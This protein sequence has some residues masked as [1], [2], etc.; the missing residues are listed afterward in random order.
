MKDNYWVQF[1]DYADGNLKDEITKLQDAEDLRLQ[2]I[3]DASKED[4]KLPTETN[5]P[6]A[7]IGEELE[8][9]LD[10]AIITANKFVI[11]K[12]DLEDFQ[13]ANFPLDADVDLTDVIS[14]YL[15]YTYHTEVESFTFD[16]DEATNSYIIYVM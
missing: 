9:E 13:S 8:N 11:D 14:E 4:I 1:V 7:S 15:M 16:Y 6:Q 5:Q 3:I 10:E 12:T 2:K